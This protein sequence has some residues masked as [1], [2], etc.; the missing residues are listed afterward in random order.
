MPKATTETT[1]AP[2]RAPRRRAVKAKSAPAEERE[3]SVKRVATSRPRRKAP[4]KIESEPET[5]VG[6]RAPL[7]K[8]RR[9][10]YIKAGLL[11]T[12][13]ATAAI[14]G[15]SDEGQINIKSLIEER[16]FLQRDFLNDHD[17]ATNFKVQVF[18]KIVKNYV[19][20]IKSK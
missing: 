6:E 7:V 11:L 9:G 20:T 12:S 4:T 8:V 15:Y 5:T 13:F 16:E 3:E 19:E 14:I 17:R 18:T 2:K 10:L 1:E